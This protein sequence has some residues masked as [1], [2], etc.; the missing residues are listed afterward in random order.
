[1]QDLCEITG[2]IGTKSCTGSLSAVVLGAITAISTEGSGL[3]H[4][5]SLLADVNSKPLL[6]L[7]NSECHPIS[8]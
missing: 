4:L 7:A 2:V 1:M 8:K 5:V 3:I 6:N